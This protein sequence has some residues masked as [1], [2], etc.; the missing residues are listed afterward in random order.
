MATKSFPSP[1]VQKE[2]EAHEFARRMI[3]TGIMPLETVSRL[4]GVDIK[5]VQELAVRIKWNS[6]RCD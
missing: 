6:V 5:T 2:N 1:S 4:S 3:I